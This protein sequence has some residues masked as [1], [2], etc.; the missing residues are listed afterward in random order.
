VRA[1]NPP[2]D[3][4]A[5]AAP[6]WGFALDLKALAQ[7]P[8][9]P[10]S[11]IVRD[12]LPCGYATLFAG[13]GGAGKSSIA[14][15][16]AV[17][18][19]LGRDF[20]GIPCQQRRVLYLAGEDRA[21]VLHWRLWHIC[22]Y[23]AI[24][25]ADL[26][27]NLKLF[28]LVGR[29]TVLW[30]LDPR[31]GHTLTGAFGE[32]DAIRENDKTQVL[33]VDGVSDTFGGNENARSEVKQFVNALLSLIPIDGALLLLAHVSKPAATNSATNEGYSGS[34]QWHN[35]ARARWYLRP[36]TEQDDDGGRAQKTGKLALELQ[37]SN[38]GRTDQSIG[39]RW[40]EDARLFLPTDAFGASAID[41]K[42]RDQTEQAGLLAAFAGCAG[43][44]PP[45]IV[46]AAMQGQ[47]TAFLV[48]SQRPEFPDSLRS[49]SRANRGR[50]WRHIETLRQLHLID[51]R[52]YRRS[53]RH[54]ASEFVLTTEG[55][56]QCVQ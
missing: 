20:F 35:A 40:D 15:H 14:L 9:D 10:P 43:A 49:N 1:V 29:D 16:L 53:N 19:A 55:M 44:D 46:P 50:F 22:T 32:L 17:C 3:N 33:I 2:L 38:F 39:L 28:D 27:G 56:R 5:N 11:F 18:I 30:R 24:D 25:M 13:H 41:R 21:N 8:P 42:H 45:M 26:R 47:R 12:W 54:H 52:G 23:L 37:K 7:R 36:E 34:T 4:G 48:L 51:E 31:S 6:H